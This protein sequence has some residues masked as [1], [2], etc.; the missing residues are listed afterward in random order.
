M[1]STPKRESYHNKREAMARKK[2]VTAN[3]KGHSGLLGEKGAIRS[4]LKKN[5]QSAGRK[6]CA[7]IFRGPG[8]REGDKTQGE[9]KKKKKKQK[10]GKDK[11]WSGHWL[12][13]RDINMEGGGGRNT[14][15]RHTFK[16]IVYEKGG[17]EIRRGGKKTILINTILKPGKHA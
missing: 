2:G 12:R 16:E 17:K 10:S 1:Q 15:L 14:A 6:S 11:S 13:E 4:E 7:S 8:D 3:Q 5:D 9:G